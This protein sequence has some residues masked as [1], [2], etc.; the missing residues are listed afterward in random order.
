MHGYKRHQLISD[1]WFLWCA[2]KEISRGWFWFFVCVNGPPNHQVYSMPDFL[3]A[4]IAHGD[5]QLQGNSW[6]S[7]LDLVWLLSYLLWLSVSVCSCSCVSIGCCVSLELWATLLGVYLYLFPLAT[8]H[9][10]IR[11]SIMIMNTR[12]VITQANVINTP[13]RSPP[14]PSESVSNSQ[15]VRSDNFTRSAELLTI[16]YR[17]IRVKA[18]K[19]YAHESVEC[20]LTV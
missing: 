20:H 19:V 11:H 6:H 10:M 7:H 17:G 4:L 16:V 9:V 1:F 14:L 12:S 2:P 18:V 5:S 15:F 13:Q 8:M 3:A